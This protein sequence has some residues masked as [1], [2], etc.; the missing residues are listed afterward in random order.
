MYDGYRRFLGD[1]SRGRRRQVQ[2]A[3]FCYEYTSECTRSKP[4]YRDNNFVRAATAFAKQRRAPYLGHKFTPMLSTWPGFDWRR[5]NIPDMMHDVKLLCEMVLSIIIGKGIDEGNAGWRSW[6]KDATHRAECKERGIFKGVWQ[7]DAKGPLPWRLTKEQLKLLNER[8]GRVCWPHYMDRLHYRD[9]S[10]WVKRSRLWKTHRKVVLFYFILATQLRDQ[11]PILHVALFKIIWALRRLDGQVHSYEAATE[12]GI[13]PGSR[14]VDPSEIAKVHCDLIV[15]LCLLEGCLPVSHLKPALHHLV[16]FAQYTLT[17]GCLRSLWM[18]FFERYNKH[19]KNLVRDASHPEAH[20][21]NS[22]SA[23][24]AAR[25]MSGVVEDDYDI[26]KDLHHRCVLSSRDPRWRPSREVIAD[27]RMLGC[28]VDRSVVEGFKIAH[29]L[30][31]HFRAGEW[32]SFP[33]CGSV[34]TC[35]LDGDSYYGCVDMF[36]RIDDNASP[37][38]AVVRWFSKPVYPHNVPLVVHVHVDGSEVEMVYGNVIRI[39]QID[40]SRVM[41]EKSETD[42][43]GMFV[44]RDSGY[45]VT[46]SSSS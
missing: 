19:I 6:G 14:A 21:A 32:G 25:F 1:G 18:M 7:G 3:G 45:D 37:G 40:P 10:F 8:M 44:M 33:R 12:L 24:V 4:R 29:I 17:H 41:V 20:L 35:K 15:G 2:Y 5:H 30:G 28:A 27:L 34:F 9:F 26:S 36:L 39:T 11:L 31:I 43:E 38:F 46:T 42:G 23:D 16:H 13:L 22:V